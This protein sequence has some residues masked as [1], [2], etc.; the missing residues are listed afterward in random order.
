MSES[1]SIA[2]VSGGAAS[3]EKAKFDAW[4]GSASWGVVPELSF[5][6]IINTK[7]NAIATKQ[8][9]KELSIFGVFFIFQEKCLFS[10]LFFVL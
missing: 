7:P 1:S 4:G 8:N 5:P 3:G 10:K 2:E 9:L 6:F